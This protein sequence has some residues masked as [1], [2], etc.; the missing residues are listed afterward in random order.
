[1]A[2]SR[3]KITLTRH[4]IATLAKDARWHSQSATDQRDRVTWAGIAREAQKTLDW[5]DQRNS[6]TTQP[7]T[8][9][10]DR[11]LDMFVKDDEEK[12]G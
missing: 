5:D 1:M 12:C 7:P 4:Q 11:T 9:A 3:L 6:T 2:N 10:A 8:P